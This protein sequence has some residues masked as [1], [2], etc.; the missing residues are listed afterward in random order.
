[1][2]ISTAITGKITELIIWNQQKILGLDVFIVYF[3][4]LFKKGATLHLTL[5]LS[6]NSNRANISQLIL[7]GQYNL[8]NQNLTIEERKRTDP[9]SVKTDTISPNKLNLAAY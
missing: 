9:L 7:W 3:F 1:M 2:Q 4:Q 5:I 6:A 8:D